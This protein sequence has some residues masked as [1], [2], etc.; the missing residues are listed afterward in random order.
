MGRGYTLYGDSFRY[1]GTP[2]KSL[3]D[4]RVSGTPQ[5]TGSPDSKPIFP[6]GGTPDLQTCDPDP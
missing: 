1:H 6:S 3:E 5:C 4:L 2:E